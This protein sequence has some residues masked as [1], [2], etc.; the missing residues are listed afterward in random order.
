MTP[1]AMRPEKALMRM[2]IHTSSDICRQPVDHVVRSD[3]PP[4]GRIA[5]VVCSGC[6]GASDESIYQ[7]KRLPVAGAPGRW[8]CLAEEAPSATI[9]MKGNKSSAM[10]S[11]K[12]L[13]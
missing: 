7:T 3:S 6:Q 11:N 12:I 5:C 1:T 9:K 8:L 4:H 10:K 2:E 13:K